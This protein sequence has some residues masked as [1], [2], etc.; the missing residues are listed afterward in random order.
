VTLDEQY[1][2]STYSGADLSAN[3]DYPVPYVVD[4][5]A[6]LQQ[7]IPRPFYCTA[8]ERATGWGYFSEHNWYFFTLPNTVTIPIDISFIDLEWQWTDTSGAINP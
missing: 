1:L 8:F 3:V 7:P 5:S 4:F 6:G 2:Y